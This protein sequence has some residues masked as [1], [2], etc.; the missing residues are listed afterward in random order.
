M[1]RVPG[2][3]TCRLVTSGLASA[4]A[5]SSRPNPLGGRRPD[6]IR[7]RK[8]LWKLLLA[9]G[10]AAFGVSTAGAQSFRAELSSQKVA[11]GAT[12]AIELRLNIRNMS[13]AELALLSWKLPFAGIEDDI[14]VVTC[15]G[16]RAPYIGRLYKRAPPTA[17]DWVRIPPGKEVSG[18]LRPRGLVRNRRG[19]GMHRPVPVQAR[20]R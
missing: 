12:E 11:Y 8:Y 9:I 2:R 4:A 7:T 3:S 18:T 20:E 1:P 19:R 15:G 5:N 14:F 16:K 6:R 17:A 13:S 10:V